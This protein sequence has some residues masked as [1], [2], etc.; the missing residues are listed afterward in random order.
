MLESGDDAGIYYL[1]Q[2]IKELDSEIEELK[3]EISSIQNTL[4]RAHYLHEIHHAVYR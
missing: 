1:S 4:K 3:R 2:K